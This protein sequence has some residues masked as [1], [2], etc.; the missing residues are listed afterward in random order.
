MQPKD[1]DYKI[2][3]LVPPAL[4]SNYRESISN[5]LVDQC[6]AKDVPWSM[7]V[8]NSTKDGEEGADVVVETRE[9]EFM[10]REW[11]RSCQEEKQWLDFPSNGEN[12][13]ALLAM[14]GK[15]LMSSDAV[16]KTNC[17]PMISC[18][19]ERVWDFFRIIAKLNI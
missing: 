19:R 16:S 18:G 10:S 15:Y 11:N 7:A 9:K 6:F 13:N 14:F 1:S 12:K 2:G 8:V 3:K 17:V 5:N 4:I